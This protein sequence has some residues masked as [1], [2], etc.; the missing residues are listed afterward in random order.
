MVEE[1]P[2]L[3]GVATWRISRRSNRILAQGA[4][5]PRS[6]RKKQDTRKTQEER[7]SGHNHV[8][9]KQNSTLQ[10]V[11]SSFG[12]KSSKCLGKIRCWHSTIQL[13]VAVN[14]PK[15]HH[16]PAQQMFLD[17]L[18]AGRLHMVSSFTL[19]GI[20]HDGPAGLADHFSEVHRNCLAASC[21]HV[22][23]ACSAT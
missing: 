21:W 19:S 10:T 13:P 22:K 3:A 11:F 12:M 15:P 8:V 20:S 7:R 23:T 9:S 17:D 2:H 16:W 1:S 6:K 4:W 5:T 14:A 18:T